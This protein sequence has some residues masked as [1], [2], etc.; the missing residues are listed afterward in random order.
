MGEKSANAACDNETPIN[1]VKQAPMGHLEMLEVLILCVS[2]CLMCEY[3]VNMS[4]N[5]SLWLTSASPHHN[6]V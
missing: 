5:E 6:Q 3:H 1:T 2:Q 4:E